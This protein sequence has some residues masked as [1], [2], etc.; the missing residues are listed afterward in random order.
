MGLSFVRRP[1]WQKVWRDLWLYRGRTVLVILSIAVGVFAVGMIAGAWNILQREMPASYAAVE[2][3][4]AILYTGDFDET[5]LQTVRRLPG[6]AAAVGRRSVATRAQRADGSW[7]RLELNALSSYNAIPV[8]RI[9]PVSGAVEPADKSILIERAGQPMIDYAPEKPVLVE[10]ADNRQ[11][12]LRLTGVVYDPSLGPSTFS[13]AVYGFINLTTLAWLG[14]PQTYNQLYFTVREGRLDQAHIQAV[15]DTVREKAQK[16]G[17]RVYVVWTPTPGEHPTH[18]IVQGVLF[19]LAALGVTALV[20]SSFLVV[21]TVSALVTQQTRQIAVMKALGA[22]ERQLRQLYNGMILVYGAGAVL[23]A[24]PLATGTAILLT[25]FVAGLLN[26]DITSYHIHPLVFLLQGVVGLVTPL[27]AGWL[28]IRQGVQMPIRLAF[29]HRAAGVESMK[30]GGL[31]GIIGRLPFVSRPFLLAFR[32]TFRRKGRLVLSLLTLALGIAICIAIF[33]IYSSVQRTVTTV[34]QAWRYDA[35][36]YFEQSYLAARTL[37]LVQKAPGVATVEA[38]Y[39]MPVR[40]QR[41]DGTE[42]DDIQVVAPPADTALFA[43]LL[44]AGRWLTAADE[45]GVVINAQLLDREPGLGIGER[46]TVKLNEREVTWTIVGIVQGSLDGPRLYLHYEPFVHALRA[47]GE[48]NTLRLALT[49][50]D[51]TGQGVAITALTD[52]LQQVGLKVAYLESTSQVRGRVEFQFGI[53]LAFLTLMA[54]LMLLVGGIG[55]TGAMSIS[56]LERV[57][58][59]GVMRA[60]GAS[61]GAILRLFLSEGIVVALLGWGLAAPLAWPLSQFLCAQ[62]GMV[63]IQTP[64]HFSFSRL[65]LFF[66]LGFILLVAL[67][68]TFFPARQATRLS[69]RE[70]LTYE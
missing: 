47:V 42:S 69:V 63:L 52:Y 23:I 50:T 57:G 45:D 20:V 37:Q 58:E 55:L 60:I 15:A 66:S 33:T 68:A 5:L 4:S 18:D 8:N 11:R 24:L 31:A 35:T 27:V 36:I 39:T 44:L 54:I 3:A 9:L 7:V 67:A 2:P 26:F 62:L 1:R 22:D 51:D 34:S 46:M 29:S 40:I 70:T 65:G 64:L 16:A 28:P 61:N 56:V 17:V 38:W 59:I 43:P 53:L 12:T 21:N 13:G 14:Q 49:A 41:A 30:G 6:V 25:R 10:M 32:N 19:L 48:T